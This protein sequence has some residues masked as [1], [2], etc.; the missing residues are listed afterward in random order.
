MGVPIQEAE[1]GASPDIDDLP[2]REQVRMVKEAYKTIVNRGEEL[3]ASY[4]QDLGESGYEKARAAAEE[5][6][7]AMGSIRALF[8]TVN[9]FKTIEN[10][11]GVISQFQSGTRQMMTIIGTMKGQEKFADV[12]K[13]RL[14]KLAGALGDFVELIKKLFAGDYEARKT[15]AANPAGEKKKEED[16]DMKTPGGDE[17]PGEEP[18]EEAE[19]PPDV[20]EYLDKNSDFYEEMK[21]T[22]EQF[23]SGALKGMQLQEVNASKPIAFL[24]DLQEK[25]LKYKEA[26][27][28]KELMKDKFKFRQTMKTYKSLMERY[29][30]AYEQYREG[31]FDLSFAQSPEEE[32]ALR[33]KQVEQLKNTLTKYESFYSVVVN[34][35]QTLQ[36]G[37]VHPKTIDTILGLFPSNPVMK[38]TPPKVKSMARQNAPVVKSQEKQ[39]KRVEKAL[40]KRSLSSLFSAGKKAFKDMFAFKP[41]NKESEVE[42][43][44]EVENTKSN[45]RRIKKKKEQRRQELQKMFDLS[46]EFISSYKLGQFL[47]DNFERS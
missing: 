4:S 43:V 8:P 5:I 40:E 26:V 3:I 45:P 2:F 39:E 31:N 21:R 15:V 32:E 30:V 6:W 42:Y 9:P 27:K 29:V 13:Q 12:S 10:M 24:I 16:P 46:S 36:V 44:E 7:K 22:L 18:P 20:K 47:I 17:E 19:I 28:N 35:Q 25:I 38:T 37:K 11:D 33:Y 14:S 41:A 23:G 34:F 1:E